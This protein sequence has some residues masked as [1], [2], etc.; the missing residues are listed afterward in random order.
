MKNLSAYLVVFA[1]LLGACNQR[2]EPGVYSSDEL[3]DDVNEAE[4]VALEPEHNAPERLSKD[5][6]TLKPFKNFQEL[7]AARLQLNA[8]KDK[9]VTAQQEVKFDF[10]VSNFTLG[11]ASPGAEAIDLAQSE[12]GQHI[13]LI[14][15]NG[16][17]SAHYQSKFSKTF[18]PGTHYA[19]AFL[20]RSYHLSLKNPEAYQAFQFTVEEAMAN[21]PKL[22]PLNEPMLFYSRP[23]GTYSGAEAQE[24]L[25]DFYL[26]NADLAP[27]GYSVL[28]T[29]NGTT[30]FEIDEW[31]PF[32]LSG[33]PM[34]ENTITLE[35]VDAQGRPVNASVNRISRT[36][37]LKS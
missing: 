8:P 35:L 25:F 14:V 9:Q 18:A 29:I 28:A 1:M 31:I 30:T 7:P 19:L 20:S 11:A 27:D 36:F 4:S 2:R 26:I 23:K 24:L 10:T 37:T 13:H 3:K 34:G 33:L 21:E 12:K 5:G 32:T 16:P 6:I 17:Y 15:D 22:Y